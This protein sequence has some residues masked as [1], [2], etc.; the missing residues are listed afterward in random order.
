MLLVASEQTGEKLTDDSVI[1]RAGSWV[2]TALHFARER[3][4]DR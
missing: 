4:G 1:E 2:V 3:N